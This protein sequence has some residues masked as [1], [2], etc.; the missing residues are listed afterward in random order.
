MANHI[1]VTLPKNALEY[2][3]K[4]ARHEYNSRSAVARNHLLREIYTQMVLDAR[5][6]GYSIRKISE[7]TKI[8]YDIVLKILAETQVDAEEDDDDAEQLEDL[9]KIR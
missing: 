3:D 9:K 1:S 4:K 6:E 2:I 5:R 8:P 7:N